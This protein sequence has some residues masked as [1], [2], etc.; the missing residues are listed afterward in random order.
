MVTGVNRIIVIVAENPGIAP[1]TIP[2]AV[3]AAM[4]R[5]INGFVSIPMAPLS[6]NRNITLLIIA[7][8]PSAS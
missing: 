6:C 4:P 1:N 7:L 5:S 2:T 8:A 3:P